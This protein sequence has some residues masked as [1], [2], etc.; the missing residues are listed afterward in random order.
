M[1]AKIKLKTTSFFLFFVC[2][3][4]GC[5]DTGSAAADEKSVEQAKKEGQVS[6]YTTMAMTESKLVADAFQS[7]YPLIRVDITR[8]G[9]EK[10]LQKILQEHRVGRGLFDVTTNSGFEMHLLNKLGVMGRYVSPEAQAFAADSRDPSGKWVDMYSNLRVVAYNTRLVPNEKV[11]GRY[12]DLLNPM[13]RKSIGFPEGQ[14]SWYGTMLRVMG[15]ESGRKF[16]QALGRQEL[17]YR[18]S[19]VLITQFVA[20]GEFNVGFVYENQVQRFKK[21]GAPL[22]IAP[23]PFVT[24]NMHPIGL[25]ASAPHPYATR[26]FIDFVLSKEGQTIIKNLGR[27]I[28]RTDILQKDLSRFK[29]IAEDIAL[30]DRINQIKEDYERYLQ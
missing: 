2:I 11:P 13:W 9:S 1:E 20:A 4:L 10:L 5:P 25:S 17:Q 16:M 30:A 8:L 7:K 27:V 14:Y 24:K 12:E 26:L 15:E 6:F 28:S 23:I 18:P 19:Q 21:Q 3:T 29:M 22:G